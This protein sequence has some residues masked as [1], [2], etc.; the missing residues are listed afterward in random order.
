MPWPIFA[1][2]TNHDL[3]AIYEFLKAIPPAEPGSCRARRDRAVK[4]A[5]ERAL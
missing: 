2:M 4:L 3:R 1:N 5:S